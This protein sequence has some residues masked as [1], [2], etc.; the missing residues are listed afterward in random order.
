MKFKIEQI[1]I[2]PASAE[3]AKQLLRE[4]GAQDWTEDTVTAAGDVWGNASENRANLSFNY[5]LLNDAK[6]F[7]ILAYQQ[8]ENW[9]QEHSP[10]V[11]HL[12][13]H[14]TAEELERWREFFAAREIRVAQEVDTSSH[15]NP[16]LI[17]TGRKYHY[18]IFDTR[19]ILGVDLKFIVR[20]EGE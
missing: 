18:T 14:V 13:M 16:F 8:G 19:D 7:E 15:T 17:E 6:E 1:A 10:S 5:E 11:S 4:I 9:M 20:R 12:G 2:A 3:L